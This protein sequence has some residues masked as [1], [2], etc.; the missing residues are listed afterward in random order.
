M[1]FVEIRLLTLI[2]LECELPKT[3]HACMKT[4]DICRLSDFVQ[5]RKA[6]LARRS[7]FEMQSLQRLPFPQFLFSA[8]NILFWTHEGHFVFQNKQLPFPSDPPPSP[9][10]RFPAFLYLC[11]TA[12]PRDVTSCPLPAFCGCPRSFPK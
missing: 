3:R 2:H 10:A 11:G 6:L 8:H 12:L 7:S 1:K 4:Q 9:F 5:A